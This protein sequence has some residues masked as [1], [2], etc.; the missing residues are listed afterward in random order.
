MAA[1]D[2]S[3]D[4]ST[5]AGLR[6]KRS[7]TKPT[8]SGPVLDQGAAPRPILSRVFRACDRKTQM[9]INASTDW[10]GFDL[11]VLTFSR[12][13][14]IQ[15]KD[16]ISQQKNH[17]KQQSTRPQRIFPFCLTENAIKTSIKPPIS[18]S[19]HPHKRLL[20]GLQNIQKNLFFFHPDNETIPSCYRERLGTKNQQKNN[21]EITRET[22]PFP[23]SAFSLP[24][25]V[26]ICLRPLLSIPQRHREEER[27]GR[28]KRGGKMNTSS[29]ATQGN[30]TT[31][32]RIQQPNPS[33]ASP[34]LK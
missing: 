9:G 28:G 32:Y 20:Y 1:R 17:P 4:K 11:A 14:K 26:T 33:S 29:E 30:R 21:Q 5:Q 27:G 7:Q 18:S 6:P 23:Q 2:S 15:Q 12:E 22:K 34:F 16:R 24:I 19:L 10:C 13:P 3:G 25:A 31:A 8:S